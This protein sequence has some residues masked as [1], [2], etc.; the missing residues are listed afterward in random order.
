M[1]KKDAEML[2]LLQLIACKEGSEKGSR[3]WI[4]VTTVSIL[5]AD[6]QILVLLQPP[7]FISVLSVSPGVS[8][9]VR[10]S[11]EPKTYQI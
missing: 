6:I 9:E 11:L 8:L 7:S 3:F 4:Y 10:Q 5:G 1:S 2:C